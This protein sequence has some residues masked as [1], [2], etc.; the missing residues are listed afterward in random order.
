M[1]LLVQANAEGLS[2]KRGEILVFRFIHKTSHDVDSGFDAAMTAVGAS[3][4]N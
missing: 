2:Q 3:D 4:L 1:M